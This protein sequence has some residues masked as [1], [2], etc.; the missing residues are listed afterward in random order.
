[1]LE[2]IPDP[3]AEHKYLRDANY[4][5]LG[6]QLV[7]QLM[8]GGEEVH[9]KHE[10]AV[11]QA[12]DILFGEWERRDPRRLNPQ[13]QAKELLA[14]AEAVLEWYQQ[15]RERRKML[16][17]IFRDELTV[18]EERLERFLRRTVNPC[19]RIV[20]AASIRDRNPTEAE[21][22]IE[23]LRGQ[24]DLMR[25]SA[26]EKAGDLS[27]RSLYNLACYEA[28]ASGGPHED[29]ALR[30]LAAALDQAPPNRR[31]ELAKWA[32]KDP[33]LQPLAK[34]SVTFEELLSSVT[35]GRKSDPG[36]AQP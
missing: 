12:S 18:K 11:K 36:Q 21:T 23:P 13:L 16:R 31:V 32:K 35:R 20:I 10:P 2:R 28:G 8:H 22:Q 29:G 3:T 17:L 4:Y 19:L 34:K 5:R 27:Y 33:S 15:R 25:G 1:M 26:A 6:Y 24:A 7:A 9:L 30:Y 14:E